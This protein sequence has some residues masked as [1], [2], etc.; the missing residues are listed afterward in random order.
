MQLSQESNF[1]DLYDSMYNLM[2]KR[3][4]EIPSV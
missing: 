3:K 2:E 4:Q 1:F